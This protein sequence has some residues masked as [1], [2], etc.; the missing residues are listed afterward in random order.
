M[1]SAFFKYFIK[2]LVVAKTRQ[3]LLFIA[4][5]GLVLSSF[6][7]ISIQG[8]MGGLQQS[9]IERSKSYFGLGYFQVSNQEEAQ[10]II[11]ELKTLKLTPVIEWEVE[12]LARHNEYIAP[13]ILHGYDPQT[14]SPF[15]KKKDHQGIIL[16][17]DLA[18]KLKVHF[19]DSL[20][21]FSP[22]T[23]QS[24]L[25]E[26]PRFSAIDVSDLLLSEVSEIDQFHA[27]V[28]LSFLQNLRREKK[29]NRV[30]IFGESG[31]ELPSSVLKDD[32]FIS[33][34]KQHATLVWSLNLETKVMFLLF[35]SMSFLVAI[36]IT[37]GLL[38]F[39]SKIRLDLASFW[40]LG[41]S[42]EQLLKMTYRF[43]AFLSLAG[44]LMGTMSGGIFLK[45][46]EL[47]GHDVMPDIFVE[48][49][50]PVEMTVTSF[51]VS[52]LVPFFISMI[53]THLSFLQFKREQVSFLTLLRRA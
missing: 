53:F 26:V 29:I 8:I 5:F 49:N 40:I 2:Y 45:I 47:Y 32:R 24:M 37:S 16:G 3:R 15:L 11:S 28:R 9:L 44:A 14:L 4:F 27:W 34:E 21:I 46:L 30:R 42:E 10:K 48:R 18:H 38:L 52:F 20:Q 41:A 25:G 6:A 36:A 19:L 12:L 22:A 1:F 50:L 7:L 33:W 23:T 13:V 43:V 17:V 39:F 35:L 51:L 31:F